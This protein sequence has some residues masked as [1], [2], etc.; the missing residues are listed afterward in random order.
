MNREQALSHL[1]EAREAITR[2]IEEIQKAP[3]YDDSE[4]GVDMQHV[5]HHINTAWN[6]RN[7]S[8]TQVEQATDTMFNRWNAFPLDLPM[9]HVDQAN[10][11]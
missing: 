3:D 4:Y 1:S 7:A 5:Y 6:S 9:M 2:M 10:E 8:S 11:A